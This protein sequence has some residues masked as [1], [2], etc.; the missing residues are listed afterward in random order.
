MIKLVTDRLGG[1]QSLIDQI[2][3]LAISSEEAIAII[4]DT[5][6]AP[7]ATDDHLA[8]LEAIVAFDGTRPSFLVKDNAIDFASSYNT[9]NWTTDLAPYF[10]ALETFIA[11]VGRVEIGE[12]HIG[13]AFLVTP[14]LAITNRHV[15]QGFVRFSNGRMVLVQDAFV[16][17]GGE[18]WNGKRSV[19]RRSVEA[20]VFAGNQRSSATLLITAN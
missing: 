14:I 15:A 8:S 20:V 2:N 17:F 11:C 7:K 6:E 16:D 3:R 13:T 18:D 9:G 10:K 1:D 12:Q 19:D 5:A 4:S